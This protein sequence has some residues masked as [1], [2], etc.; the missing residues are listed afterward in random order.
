M[1]YSYSSTD[2]FGT[3]KLVVKDEK[4]LDYETIEELHKIKIIVKE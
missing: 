4:A 1:E 2:G 3:L